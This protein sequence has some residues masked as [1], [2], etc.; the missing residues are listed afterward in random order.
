[1]NAQ[2]SRDICVFAGYVHVIEFGAIRYVHA[3]QFVIGDILSMRVDPVNR[4][5]SYAINADVVFVSPIRYAE[6]EHSGIDERVMHSAQQQ[7]DE[8]FFDA[9]SNDEIVE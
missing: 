2:L 9:A 7:L 6:R 8:D 4:N 5:V 1:M 3:E